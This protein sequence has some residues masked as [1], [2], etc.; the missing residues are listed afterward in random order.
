MQVLLELFR[1]QAF[2]PLELRTM[3]NPDTKSATVR[4]KPVS[5]RGKFPARL[6]VLLARDA[7]VGLVIR[8]GPSKTVCTVLWNR[9]RDTFKLGQW[10][11]GRIY[12]RRCDLS[13]DGRH[14]IYFA[15]NGRWQSEA[16]GSWTAI[17]RV[18]YLKATSLFAKGDCWHGGGLFLTDREFWLNDGHGHTALKT[19]MDVCRNEA[20]H[21]PA[22]FGGECL[23]VYYNR[24]QRDGWV[25]HEKEDQGTMLFEKKLP[26]GWL[27][28]KMAFAEI[29]APPG[30]G[31]YWDA[32]E[33]R[34]ES[35]DAV[36]AFPEWEWADFVDGRLVFAVDGSLREARLGR[37]RL[38]GEK[39]LHDFNEMRFEAIAA[40]Y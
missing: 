3:S 35:T 1:L 31:C 33:L 18:P 6:H 32:H 11:R 13:P 4:P 23:T 38:F 9:K 10:M 28:R 8:R 15:M 27:L 26:K 16:K 40:P 39:L 2:A 20:Y 37:A 17:S 25:M 36:L 19:A 24:L 12:E 29:G 30:R 21:P 7:K 5:D 14:F 22:D 34:H